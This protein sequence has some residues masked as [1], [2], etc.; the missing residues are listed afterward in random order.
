[1]GVGYLYGS[2]HIYAS[3]P[4]GGSVAGDGYG[5]G[6]SRVTAWA[7][8]TIA[9]M[10]RTIAMTSTA[11]PSPPAH[12]LGRPQTRHGPNPDESCHHDG[13]L[14]N[15]ETRPNGASRSRN[16]RTDQPAARAACSTAAIDSETSASVSVRSGSRNDS[17]NAR[18]TLSGSPNFTPG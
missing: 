4:G 8:A 16:Q 15:R 6:F 10:Y 1:M 9:A 11:P 18:L 17:E 14:V 3:H 5:P 12:L 7:N 13:C 2:L